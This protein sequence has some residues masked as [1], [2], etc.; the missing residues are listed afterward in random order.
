MHQLEREAQDDPFLMDALE[1]YAVRDKDQHTNL[2]ELQK[3]LSDRVNQQP[4]KRIILWPVTA[5]A[6]SVLAF[7]AI[8]LW[9]YVDHSSAPSTVILKPDKASVVERLAAPV[10]KSLPVTVNPQPQLKPANNRLSI[11]HSRIKKYRIT[12][13]PASV[14]TVPVIAMAPKVSP[15]DSVTKHNMLNEVIITGY[16][17]QRKKDVS[18]SVAMISPNTIVPSLEGRVA[19]VSV[20]AKPKKLKDSLRTI[21]GQIISADDKQPITGA[22]VTVLGKNKGAVTDSNGRYT[23]EV[24]KDDHIKVAFIGY[25]TQQIKA[26]GDN[27]NVALTPD[28]KALSEVVIGYGTSKA[29]IEE[30]HPRDGWESFRKY[31]NNASSPDNKK[32]KVRLRFVVNADNMLSDFKITK[33]LSPYADA[34]ALHLIKEGPGWIHNVNGEPETVTVTIKFK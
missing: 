18:A 9:F 7:L 13:A 27:L 20:T 4:K 21:T 15:A 2:D 11:V 29:I 30:A 16:T 34:E 26:K 12:N 23:I 32:G 19:G 31:L 14:E 5:V 28:Q 8:G 3:R 33:S 10:S 6:A 1:G 24:A 17:A 25:N 22:T